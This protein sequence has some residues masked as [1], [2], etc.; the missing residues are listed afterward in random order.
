MP[1]AAAQTMKN[2]MKWFKQPHAA[3]SLH[4]VKEPYQGRIALLLPKS[5]Y[6]FEVPSIAFQQKQAAHLG[7]NLW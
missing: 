5:L 6:E 4:Q 7:P 2:P 1:F 3:M